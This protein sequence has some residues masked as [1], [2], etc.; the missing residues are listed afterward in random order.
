MNRRTKITPKGGQMRKPIRLAIY[1]LYSL[2]L[3]CEFRL[4]LG[5]FWSLV[6]VGGLVL[7]F[8]YHHRPLSYAEACYSVFLLVFLEPYLDF[9]DEWYLQPLFF[10]IPIIGL[11]AVADSLVRLG[12]LTFTKKNQ[13]PEW[14]RM[15]ASLYRDHVLV[16]G[17]GK[18]GFQIIK[19]IFALRE[20]IVA[21]ER[22]GIDSPLL[23]EVLDLGIPVIRG[24]GRTSKVL[25]QAGVVHARSVIVAT[26]DDLTNLDAGLTAR[27]LNAHA[28]IVLRL[29]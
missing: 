29:F 19:G 12:F 15:I 28:K 4:S 1:A 6:F 14:Q 10:L 3:L 18:V 21:V 17:V 27:D 13:L 24:D 11:G 23:E 7:R 20:P 26:S 5:V 16:V 9:P 22:A 8:T 25:E 2:S